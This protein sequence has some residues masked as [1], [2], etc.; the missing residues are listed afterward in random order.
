MP[1]GL[2]KMEKGPLYGDGG[3]HLFPASLT[4]GC[5]LHRSC[6]PFMIRKVL[7]FNHIYTMKLF[8]PAGIFQTCAKVSMLPE[9]TAM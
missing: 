9:M 3:M 2:K 5:F 1:K 4:N 8:R 6:V 7:Q